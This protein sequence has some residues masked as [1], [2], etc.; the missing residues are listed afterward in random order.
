MLLRRRRPV[1]QV[2]SIRVARLN[3]ISPVLAYRRFNHIILRT[4][5]HVRV[6]RVRNIVE[7]VP[8]LATVVRATGG[9]LSRSVVPEV[10][11]DRRLCAAVGP[12]HGPAPGGDA[13]VVAPPVVRLV[14][15]LVDGGS[16]VEVEELGAEVLED[17]GELGVVLGDVYVAWVGRGARFIGVVAGQDRDVLM[18]AVT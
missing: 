14:V 18:G 1:S 17:G 4:P 7:S 2:L 6:I 8:Q 13:A 10:G 15:G 12:V 11:V 5:G 9:I 3:K 16:W